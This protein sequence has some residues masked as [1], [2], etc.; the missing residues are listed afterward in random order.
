MKN[1]IV[2]GNWK[3]NKTFSEADD[4]IYAISEG[5][6]D[7]ELETDVIICP[8]YPYLEMATDA[9]EESNFTVGAHAQ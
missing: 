9:A 8:P 7:M 2:A 3:M 5:L 1:K 4:L 6:N